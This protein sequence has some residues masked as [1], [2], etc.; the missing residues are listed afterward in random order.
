MSKFE[1][2][3]ELLQPGETGLF[4]HTD[5]RYFTREADGSGITGKWCIRPTRQIDRVV[6]VRWER[7]GGRR[8]WMEFAAAG[9]NPV[10]YVSRLAADPVS[11]QG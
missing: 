9:R 11:K 8:S 5:G 4:V 1:T 10:K 3:Q 2:A 7:C 6:I